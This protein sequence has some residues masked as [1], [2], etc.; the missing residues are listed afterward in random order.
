MH[1]TVMMHNINKKKY[2][3]T[4]LQKYIFIR[5]FSAKCNIT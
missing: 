1:K 2:L 3:I 4:T 5:I